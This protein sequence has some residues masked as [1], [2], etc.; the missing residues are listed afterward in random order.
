A[1]VQLFQGGVGGSHHQRNV[2]DEVGQREN[3]VGSHQNVSKGEGSRLIEGQ[4]HVHGHHRGGQGP[5]KHDQDVEQ[6][7]SGEFSL[8][9]DVGG[10]NSEE[11]IARGGQSGHVQTVFHRLPDVRVLHQQPVVL[12]AEPGRVG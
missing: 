4:D 9:Q 1:V 12:Q 8:D 2:A 10:E 11:K 7:F 3:P 6:I 5:G